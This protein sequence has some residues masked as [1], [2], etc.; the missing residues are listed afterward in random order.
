MRKNIKDDTSHHKLD[1][2]YG[3][4]E[5]KHTAA[6]FPQIQFLLQWTAIA[7]SAGPRQM[8]PRSNFNSTG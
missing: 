5:T 4:L 2:Y 8:K 6:A 1:H 3:R 7:M